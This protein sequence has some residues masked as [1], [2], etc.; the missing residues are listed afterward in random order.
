[1]CLYS[2]I[3]AFYSVPDICNVY[4]YYLS[5]SRL[6]IAVVYLITWLKVIILVTTN[7]TQQT[8]KQPYNT[9]FQYYLFSVDLLLNS[10]LALVLFLY[11]TDEISS[12]SFS[13]RTMY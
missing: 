5:N 6:C 10:K 7:Y 2:V 9:H 13:F 1:M 8:N 4:T 3:G 12:F 11:L